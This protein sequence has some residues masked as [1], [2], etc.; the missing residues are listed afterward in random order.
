ML[1][2]LLKDP[3]MEI[4]GG[5]VAERSEA[6]CPPA[7][8]DR[9]IALRSNQAVGEPDRRRSRVTNPN[10]RLSRTGLSPR[11]SSHAQGRD[12]FM[13]DSVN[14]CVGIDVSKSALDIHVLPERRTFQVSNSSAG[15]AQLLTRLPAPGTCRIVLEATGGYERR[16]VGELVAAGHFVSVAN[17]RQVRDF[18]KAHG[19]LAKTDRIDAQ[20][21]ARFARDVKPRPVAQTSQKQGELDQLVTRRRQ[22][23][24][25]RTAETNRLQDGLT[26]LVRQSVQRSIDALTKD[27][28]RIDRAILELVQSDDDWKHRFELLKTVPGVGD[29]TAAA[30]VA[31]L[32][33][34][35]HL[36]RQQISAL[37]GV[38]PYPDDSGR[39]S[40]KRFVRGGRKT[41]RSTLY[42]AALS[43]SIHNPILK[44]F[45]Q[46]LKA[47]G[48][49]AKVVLTACI[50]KLLV[51][52]NTMV[53]NNT[54]WKTQ[55]A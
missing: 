46:R 3:Q 49:A 29:V 31:E 51:I 33:E 10:S 18:A 52:L 40:G 53:K 50:R 24:Q 43:A 19:I 22:L 34:L 6:T 55:I 36:N 7:A 13:N 47:H 45:A 42:M 11:T 12:P 32:P 54:P 17:P 26:K 27:L 28:V 4:A 2:S 16:L 23:L 20:V 21:I 1:H 25:L 37:V 41:L 35:G 14:L 9:S 15:H 44:Q 8:G 39:H 38:A 30:L 5:Q 48:K